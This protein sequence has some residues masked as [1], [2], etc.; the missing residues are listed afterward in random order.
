MVIRAIILGLV[1]AVVSALANTVR[2]STIENTY[3]KVETYTTVVSPEK[4]LGCKNP[5]PHLR[6]STIVD[7]GDGTFLVIVAFVCGRAA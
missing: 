7:G 2:G 4:D 1:L 6:G 5:I 3:Q